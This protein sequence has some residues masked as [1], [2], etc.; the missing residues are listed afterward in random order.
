VDGHHSFEVLLTGGPY[1]QGKW[2]LLDHDISTGIFSPDGKS[3]L[4]IP[5]VRA[6]WKR[7]TDRRFSPEKQNGWLVCGLHPDDGGVYRRYDVAEYLAGYS[8]PPPIVHLRRG[9][10]LR[11]Y[12][13]PG[14]EDGQT[15][16]FWGRNYATDG[17]PG[18]ERSLTWVNQPDRMHGSRDGTGHKP[19]QARFANA[20]Y[21][22]RPDFTGA[23]GEGVID[24]SDDH[25]TFEF[26]TPY[27]IA[28]TPPEGDPWGIYKNGCRNG[29]VLQGSADCTVS[30]SVDQGGTWHDGG[31]LRDGLDLTDIVKGHRQYFIR[32]GTGAAK[33]ARSNLKTTT[34]CQ[35]NSS[36]LPRLK[37]ERSRVD[38]AASGQGLVSAGP[39][40]PQAELH[41]VAGRFG[42][43]QVTMELK[44]PRGETA[45]AIFAVAHVNSSNPP[46]PGVKYQIEYSTDAG[47]TWRSLVRD[48]SITR[49][50][51]EPGDFWSQ[52]FC[53]GSADVRDLNSSEVLVRFRNDGGKNY[54]RGE[55]HLAYRT[56]GADKTRVTFAWEDT[57]GR[58]QAS[59][60]FDPAASAAN[61][62]GHWDLITGSKVRTRWVELEPV[63][64]PK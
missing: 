13:E 18:L 46:D 5:E 30:V 10:T 57:A 45:T 20:V 43:P 38:F 54:A 48:W 16:V 41:V 56:G 3:L 53:W 39:N 14:L 42:T 28:A 19:G 33:L 47:K 6:D 44:T 49:R 50:G 21:S 25:V 4:S 37:C 15:F 29:L 32:F 7:L 26:Y 2:V 35:A 12:L 52:S 59:H 31:A 1:Q 58:H 55:A 11:R 60:I 40:L 63:E 22:Y 64:R 24:K 8:G 61:G 51:D 27:I 36:V 9:E 62:P 17:V 23:Y 34:V